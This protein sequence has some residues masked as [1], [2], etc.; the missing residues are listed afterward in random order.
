[1]QEQR[2]NAIGDIQEGIAML[3]LE[4]SLTQENNSLMQK[5]HNTKL[6]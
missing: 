4:K 1:M 2:D 6:L 5:L 3:S